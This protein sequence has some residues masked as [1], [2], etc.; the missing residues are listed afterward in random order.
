MLVSKTPL[1]RCHYF[2]WIS[3]FY[4]QHHHQPHESL[5]AVAAVS[6]P[7]LFFHLFSIFC[8]H[9]AGFIFLFK[10]HN[11]RHCITKSPFTFLFF[12]RSFYYTHQQSTSSHTT[13]NA[14]K[15][16]SPFFFSSPHTHLSKWLRYS[17]PSVSFHIERVSTPC[18]LYTFN[19]HCIAFPTLSLSLFLS[20]CV[21]RIW[22]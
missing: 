18:K 17:S 8:A 15:P 21:L 13:P 14:H 10:I 22:R 5:S 3:A 4:H 16:H 20:W 6:I 9:C 12:R 11:M 2:A 7:H 19:F 1:F